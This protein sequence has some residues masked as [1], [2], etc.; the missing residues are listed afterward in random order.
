MGP[1]ARI[2]RPHGEQ[3]KRGA[4]HGGDTLFA[5]QHAAYET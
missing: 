5:T 2:L 4:L 3:S 1:P